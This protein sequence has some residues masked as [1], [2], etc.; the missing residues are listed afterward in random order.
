MSKHVDVRNQ[1]KEKYKCEIVNMRRNSK[2]LGWNWSYQ[3]DL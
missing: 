2:G 1:E 3:Y